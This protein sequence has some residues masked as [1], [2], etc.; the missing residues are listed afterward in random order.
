[1]LDQPVI[2]LT[3]VWKI[4]DFIFSIQHF[5]PLAIVLRVFYYRKITLFWAVT[6]GNRKALY[7]V[8]MLVSWHE[9]TVEL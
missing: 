6:L 2:L 1:M 8:V 9:E 4:V 7:V 5:P 3:I